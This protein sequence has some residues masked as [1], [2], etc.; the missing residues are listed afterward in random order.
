VAHYRVNAGYLPPDHWLHDPEQG[1]GRIIGE[2]CH[3][4]DFLTFL[5]GKPPDTVSALGI[6]DNGRYR[7]D[8]VV[9]TFTFPDGSLGTL[10]YL[11]NGDKAL[12]KERLEVFSGGKVGILEDFRRLELIA[13]GRRER[14]RSPLRQDKGHRA[15]WEAFSKAILSGGYPPIPYEHLLGVTRATFAAVESLRSRETV[16]IPK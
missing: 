14:V 9:F 5:V 4:I 15:E 1:G 6:P 12:P 13:D 10:A 3:F 8:N 7:E 2:G 11:A 16:A